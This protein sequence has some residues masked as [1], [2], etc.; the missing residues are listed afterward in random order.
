VIYHGGAAQRIRRIA[1][2]AAVFVAAAAAATWP[3]AR[4]AGDSL[5]AEAR[6]PLLNAWILAWDA[7]RAIHGF[8]GIWDA[9]ILYPYRYTLAF[10]EHLFG[11]ALFSAPIQWLSGNPILAYN[12][13]F[14]A[15]YVLAGAGMYLLARELTGRTD[16]ALAAAL[17]FE[18]CPYRFAQLARIQI[19]CIGWM[20]V[21]LWALHRYARRGEARWIAVATAAFCLLGL[22]NGYYLYFLLLPAALVAFWI[23]RTSGLAF[24]RMAV[25]ALL[26]AAVMAAVFAPIA[27][28]YL[29]AR[30]RYDLKRDVSDNARFSADLGS[31][32]HVTPAIARHF[33][34]AAWLP[35]FTKPDGPL[36][37]KEGEL[38][39]GFIVIALAI[40]S[41]KRREDG[42]G[43][44]D[45]L[46]HEWVWRT[47][48]PIAL[49]GYVATAVALGWNNVT[50]PLALWVLLAR[51]FVPFPRT[52]AGVY[53]LVAIVALVLSLGPEPTAWGRLFWPASPYA[54]L[55]RIL[56][57][58]DSL[59]V[60]A[61]IG[62]VVSLA[63]CVM[64]GIGA[65]RVLIDR[66]LAVR[67][68]LLTAAALL[69]F[70]DTYG[71]GIPLASIGRRGR[72]PE[73]AVYEWIAV[74]PP[75]AVLELPVGRM[76]YD[77]RA[78]RAEYATLIHGHPLV[79]GWTGYTTPLQQFLGGFASPLRDF[80][81]FDNAIGF[82]RGLGVRYIVI[83][84]D[85]FDDRALASQLA[86]TLATRSDAFREEE[87]WGSVAVYQLLPPY[88]T[89]ETPAG[90]TIPIVSG[91]ASH[92]GDTLR[93]ALDGNVA[94]R[95]TSAKVQ[96]GDEWVRV[97]FEAGRSPARAE[98]R[99][100][101]AVLSDYPRQLDIEA[102]YGV[103]VTPV[104]RGSA[105]EAFGQAIRRAP[106]D[107]RMRIPLTPVKADALRIRQ[108]GQSAGPW[109][110]SID[111]LA[112]YARP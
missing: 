34:P 110:W 45:G 103:A 4:H 80:A 61:R 29:E 71:G 87:H 26:A 16:A 21:G 35:D 94:T 15:S 109:W 98:F 1:A 100:N 44:P 5:P 25:H 76:D 19:E 14:F 10:S 99:V 92:R 43:S 78:F 64:A 62:M 77:Y 41:L 55:F 8:R 82:L 60:P 20:A 12:C 40:V 85:D 93:E 111:D 88:P 59:R 54:A 83:R 49:L 32:L 56:P 102:E 36:E 96:S 9:P 37:T 69:I 7:D 89:D 104:F 42:P 46:P 17:A 108:T 75:G 2:L 47:L 66:S 73:R 3:L 63:L 105:M 79:N 48:V 107:I 13:A 86:A 91:T 57:G 101:P 72:L 90:T 95:W 11:V 81:R 97:S 38:F 70:A 51:A 67:S 23:L 27:R 24:R 58:L 33:P 112:I 74:Q 106:E 50:V 18:M 65:A 53:A 22:S 31:Y 30:Q 28:V 68:V 52:I 84:P 39:P 6:D